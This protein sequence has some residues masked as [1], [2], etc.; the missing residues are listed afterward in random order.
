ME[1]MI[2][3]GNFSEIQL[4]LTDQ[5]HRN[6]RRYKSLDALLM[7]QLGEELN[8]KYSIACSLKT[9]PQAIWNTMA[10]TII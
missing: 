4:W 3:D 9:P 2:E 8:P 6:G 10:T 5:V 7:D 1:S